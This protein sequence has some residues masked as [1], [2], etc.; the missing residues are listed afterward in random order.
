MV[1][2]DLKQPLRT[3]SGYARILEEDYKGK[4]DAEAD[5]IIGPIVKDGSFL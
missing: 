4:L 3:V 5:G 1:S 2:H